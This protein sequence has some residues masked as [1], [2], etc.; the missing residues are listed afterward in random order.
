MAT[1]FPRHGKCKLFFVH[2]TNIV[3]QKPS[4]P[5]TTRDYRMGDPPTA[6]HSSSN[7]SHTLRAQ[8]SVRRWAR[9]SSHSST[10]A[11]GTHR[12]SSVVSRAQSNYT[13]SIGD[14][15]TGF[16][17]LAMSA[18]WVNAFGQLKQWPGKVSRFLRYGLSIDAVRVD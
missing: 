1:R 14:E 17:D 10:T 12:L 18:L 4:H 11:T 9:M 13:N 15:T 7:K 3:I 16:W 6:K 8:S 2:R 5:Q